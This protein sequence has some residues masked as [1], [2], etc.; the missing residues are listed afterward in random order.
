[1]VVQVVSLAE[2]PLFGTTMSVTESRL[3]VDLSEVQGGQLA[4]HSVCD[5]T[6]DDTVDI[7]TTVIPRAFV[8]GLPRR[9][10]SIRISTDDGTERWV[11]DLGVETLGIDPS[12]VGAGP[13]PKRGTDAGVIDQ[14]K[15]GNP[16]VTVQVHVPLFGDVGV[17]VVQRASLRIDGTRASDDHIR[18]AVFVDLY[19]QEVVGAA[20][21][22][23]DMSL[24]VRPAPSGSRF[25]MWPVADDARCGSVH[26]PRLS[27]PLL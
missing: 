21:S 25:E 6:V 18:G 16:G 20:R 24:K 14:D 23:F 11:A 22:L 19:E 13:L 4:T 12:V 5:V 27:P 3:L 7:A 9:Q 2:A 15:D 26:W 8:A 1:M 10:Y 17:Y